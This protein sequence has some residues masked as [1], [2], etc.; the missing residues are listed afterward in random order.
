MGVRHTGLLMVRSLFM[1]GCLIHIQD[2]KYSQY[3]Y[4]IE[5]NGGC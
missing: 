4:R 2:L 5:R 3:G 1:K